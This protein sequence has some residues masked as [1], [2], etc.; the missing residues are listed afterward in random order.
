MPIN[1]LVGEPINRI[2]G[3]PINR[4]N[5]ELTNGLDSEPINRLVSEPINRLESEPKNRRES[6]PI[7]RLKSEPIN[8]LDGE[9]IDRLEDEPT[10][11][12]VGEPINR[13]VG[14]LIN[15]LDSLEKT[16]STLLGMLTVYKYGYTL[17]HSSFAFTSMKRLSTFC[18]F[19]CNKERD[20][21]RHGCVH[22]H[23]CSFCDEVFTTQPLLQA[24]VSAEHRRTQS[25][26]TETQKPR[27]CSPH[28]QHHHRGQRYT[29]P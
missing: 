4:L 21:Q 1:K 26:Q 24:H 28:R 19:S 8:R 9:P 27:A 12:L 5:G 2:M 7:N 15:R 20:L 10:N 23:R 16:S 6:E 18:K 22:R 17:I 29:R 25:I 3:E 13:L 14:E 11:R